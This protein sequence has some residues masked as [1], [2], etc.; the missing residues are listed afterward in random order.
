MASQVSPEDKRLILCDHCLG[1]FVVVFRTEPA[2]V[3]EAVLSSPVLNA[4]SQVPFVM[5]V[6]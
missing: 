4:R 6:P 3:T 1:L 5:S 2:L